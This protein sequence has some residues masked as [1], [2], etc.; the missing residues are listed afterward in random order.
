MIEG[1]LNACAETTTA[2][3]AGYRCKRNGRMGGHFQRCDAR[4]MTSPRARRL[5]ATSMLTSVTN[6]NPRDCPCGGPRDAEKPDGGKVKKEDDD[7]CRG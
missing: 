4:T 3:K 1:V 2:K 5:L 6:P 7:I